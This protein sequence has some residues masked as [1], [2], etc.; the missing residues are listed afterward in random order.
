[1]TAA[2]SSRPGPRADL[3]VPAALLDTA[4]R[5]FAQDGVGAVSLRAIGR[6]AGVSSAAVLYHHSTKPMLVEAVLRRRGAAVGRELS[7]RL[8][9]LLDADGPVTTRDLV[10]AVLVPMVDVVNA[11]PEGG[12]CWVKLFTQL[13]QANDN[14]W[15]S[16]VRGNTDLSTMVVE[17]TQRALPALDEAAIRSRLGIAMFGVLTS[18]AGADLR[19]VPDRMGPD[20][21]D[22]EFVEQLARFTAAGLATD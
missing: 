9:A 8:R 12:L 16:A 15:I 10:D 2:P 6:E 13:A 4:E 1:M 19:A 20:G 5:M 14:L 22:P 18:L 3:D 17:V 21:L 11:D 7:A